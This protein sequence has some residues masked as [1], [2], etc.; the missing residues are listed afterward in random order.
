MCVLKKKKHR[1]SVIEFWI[2]VRKPFIFLGLGRIFGLRQAVPDYSG[3]IS[4]KILPDYPAL[5]SNVCL[6]IRPDIR[7]PARK[8]ISGPKQFHMENGR[9]YGCEEK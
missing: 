6:I 1:V 7:Y 5:S 4:G 2:E 3:R 8:N 9:I